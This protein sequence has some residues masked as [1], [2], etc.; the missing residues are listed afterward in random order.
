MQDN[1]KANTESVAEVMPGMSAVQIENLTAVMKEKSKPMV[2]MR[3]LEELSCD[4]SVASENPTFL[5]SSID[6]VRP[7]LPDPNNATNNDNTNNNGDPPPQ[8][9]ASDNVEAR[10]S[11][12]SEPSGG[13]GNAGSSGAGVTG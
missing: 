5:E 1:D 7:E 12:G 13:Q 4:T 10:P 11:D 9:G 6:D 2:Q 8:N 3:V